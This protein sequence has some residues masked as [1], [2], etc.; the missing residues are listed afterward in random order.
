VRRLAFAVLAAAAALSLFFV[1]VLKPTTA[2]A[3]VLL[4]AWLLAPYVLLALG[5]LA[6]SPAWR[7]SC[8]ITAIAAAVGGTGF[9]AWLIYVQPDAQGAIAVMFTPIYQLLAVAL[10]LPICT[11]F[12]ARQR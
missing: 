10:L 11:W 12:F 9:I 5:L 8:S 2:S 1:H 4:S 6:K 3:A 7:K